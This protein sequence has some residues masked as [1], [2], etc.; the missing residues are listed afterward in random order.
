[1]SITEKLGDFTGIL[2]NGM[3]FIPVSSFLFAK[4][5]AINLD[6]WLTP[7]EKSNFYLLLQNY[8]VCKFYFLNFSQF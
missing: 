3:N 1:M 2:L 8:T 4:C 5:I 7:L 6:T